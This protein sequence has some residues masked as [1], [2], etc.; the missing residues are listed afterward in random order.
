M[1]RISRCVVGCGF[2][3][4]SLCGCATTSDPSKGGF[5]DGVQGIQSGEYQRR[6]DEKQDNVA[7]LRS[8]GAQ[9]RGEQT[10][11]N[12]QADSLEKQEQAY[13]Q[14]LVQLKN[15]LTSMEAKL[16]NAKLQSQSKLAQKKNLEQRMASLKGQVQ[17]SERAPGSNET[18]KQQDLAKLKAEKEKLQDEIIRLTSQ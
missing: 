1:K 15:D 12:R 17:K 9:L 13:R 4:F 6:A 10:A 8:T 7:S 2:L 5:F 16:R 11:L 3:M 14:Q 18:Q